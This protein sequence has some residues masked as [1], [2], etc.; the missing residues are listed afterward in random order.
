MKLSS[1]D[2]ASKLAG[3]VV[4]GHRLV[5]VVGSGPTSVVYE[6]EQPVT[7]RTV[8]FKALLPLPGYPR[9]P[10]RLAAAAEATSSLRH[11]NVVR[12]YEAGRMRPTEEDSDAEDSDEIGDGRSEGDDDGQAMHF[13]LLR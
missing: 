5:R 4:A 9:L 1:H 11:P 2:Q 10:R 7:G 3:K 6:A 13:F 8:A 12:V